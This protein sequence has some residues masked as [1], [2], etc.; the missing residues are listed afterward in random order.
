MPQIPAGW[1]ETTLGEVSDITSSKRI[2]ANEYKTSWIPFFRGKEIT[3]KFYGNSISTELFISEERYKELEKTVWVPQE[4]DILLTSVWTLGNPYLVEKGMKFYFKDWNITRFHNFKDVSPKW[5]FYRIISPIGKEILSHAKIG[6]TQ[7]AYTIISLKQLPILLPLLLPEQQAIA[8]VLSSFDDKIELLR[9]ENQTLEQMGQELFKERFGKWK[10]GD[11]LPESWRV[12]TDYIA[13]EKGV[14]VWS[15]NYYEKQSAN[16]EFLPFYRVG[17]IASNGAISNIFCDKGLLKEKI[18][19]TN[20]V[21]LSLDGT[22]GRVFI[23]WAGW[24]SSGIRKLVALNSEI[25]QAFLYFWAKSEDVQKTISL[26][27]E[28]TTIQHAGKSIPYLMISADIE[29]IKNSSKILNV[30]FDKILLNLEQIQALSATRDLLLPKLM[31][32]E[33]RVEF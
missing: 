4:G 27:S 6:S 14:E 15:S 5:L 19:Y 31:S 30:R 12:A 33:V 9:A 26:Y 1:K 18:F 17:D 2:F 20:D 10:V 23:W 7:Q 11:E 3:E 8:A 32:G 24:Y 16:F 22:V 29:K 25:S 21:L 28:W 13:F